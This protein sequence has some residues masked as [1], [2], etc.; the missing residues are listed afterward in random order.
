MKKHELAEKIYYFS[1]I[2]NSGIIKGNQGTGVFFHSVAESALK[3]IISYL[4]KAQESRYILDFS[5]IGSV[6]FTQESYNRIICDRYIL[7]G[8][9]MKLFEALKKKA[10]EKNKAFKC[11]KCVGKGD[12][13]SF[14][15][16]PCNDKDDF[17]MN[18]LKKNIVDWNE[19]TSEVCID[20]SRKLIESIIAKVL[21]SDLE[22]YD[23]TNLKYLES[24][25]VYVNC[26]LN[27][28]RLFMNIDVL[29][30]S[31]KCLEKFVC[32]NFLFANED[33][34]KICFLGV[35]NNGIILARLLA[36]AMKMDVKSINHIGPKYCLNYDN[37]SIEKYKKRKYILVS[38]VICLGG[39]YRIAKGI[40]GVLESELL[41]AVGIVKIRD[42][43]RNEK[44]NEEKI[45]TI[46]DNI[47]NH[48]CDY[49]IYVD[50]R[51]DLLCP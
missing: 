9:N 32:D 43:Y 5:N 49:K 22:Y 19:N 13:E 10:E 42:V 8:L 14:I 24:S 37:A 28:K 40:L 39:E 45:Y 15:I 35:S 6:E 4:E 44:K 12:E 7:I 23:E 21:V 34:G 51:G 25:N 17:F 11:I 33:K 18:Y 31:I 29:N 30:L 48:G 1:L 20:L 16:C 41:G 46:I 3:Q 38:D 27:V 2:Q 50:R 47:N 36:Y 26:Y